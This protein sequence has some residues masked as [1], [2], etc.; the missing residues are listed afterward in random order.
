MPPTR[1]TTGRYEPFGTGPDRYRAFIPFP[2][3]PRDP[4]IAI[5]S[6][7]SQLAERATHAVGRLEGAASLL[8]DINL[9]LYSYV[10]QEAVLPSQIEGTQSSISDVFLLDI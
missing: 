3:P 9:L 8:P 2:L 6:S 1:K 10:R 5:D 4:P 7:L